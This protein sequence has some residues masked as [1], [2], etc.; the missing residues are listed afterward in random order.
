[1]VDSSRRKLPGH[2]PHGTGHGLITSPSAVIT[3]LC[4][5]LCS[6]RSRRGHVT[7]RWSRH[8]GHVALHG[9]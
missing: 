8:T 1:M 5:S 4:T 9:S 6:G 2:V 7:Q 3:S